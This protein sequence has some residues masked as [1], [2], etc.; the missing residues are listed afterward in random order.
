MRTSTATWVCINSVE[1]GASASSR[2]D[3]A[4]CSGS[5]VHRRGLSCGARAARR[6]RVRE[7]PGAVN[8]MADANTVSRPES[9]VAHHVDGRV[10]K[11]RR[12]TSA[13][14]AQ[15]SP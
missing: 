11:G 6:S 8:T 14:P 9:V 1:P 12:T 5:V 3:W 7:R 2:G 13:L 15:H 10:T 4:L